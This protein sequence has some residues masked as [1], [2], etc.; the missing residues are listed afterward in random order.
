MTLVHELALFVAGGHGAELLQLAEAALRGVA[1]LVAS[2]VEGGRP[3]A[4][5]AA[6]TAV[7][8]LV[9]LDR[10]DRRDPALAQVSAVGRGGVRLAVHRG[11]GP[12]P[13]T[14]QAP[15]ADPDC[16]HQRNDPRAVAVLAVVAK[17][18]DGP[19]APV[20]GQ[21]DLGAQPA[22]GAAQ[23]LPARPGR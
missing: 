1:L 6:V 8:F 12:G 11:A 17:P 4:R 22:A 3:P 19:A 5:A 13:G 9:F 7:G 14:P 21:V 2:G 20:R 18:A 23:R 10:D 15:A 16:L